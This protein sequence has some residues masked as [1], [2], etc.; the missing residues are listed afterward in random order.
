MSALKWTGCAL[1]RSPS[2]HGPT[3]SW[4]VL[5]GIL[6][7]AVDWSLL[8]SR[9]HGWSVSKVVDCLVPKCGQALDGS[10]PRLPARLGSNQCW[11]RFNQV[12]EINQCSWYMLETEPV[13]YF[14]YLME[15]QSHPSSKYSIY[16]HV[17]L[18][19]I[20]WSSFRII[21][22]SFLN[23]YNPLHGILQHHK[24]FN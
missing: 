1:L 21:Y 8:T 6:S 20:I 18:K 4:R 17:V 2:S 19:P 14:E 24:N 12:I 9:K 22:L 13:I 11:I 3:L 5:G 7:L 16:I 23:I 15:C 10:D